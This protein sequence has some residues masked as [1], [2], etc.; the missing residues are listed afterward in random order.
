MTPAPMRHDGSAHSSWAE[1]A[2]H[3][4]AVALQQTRR[5][6]KTVRKSAQR[7]IKLARYAVGRLRNAEKSLYF[8]L[9]DSERGRRLLEAA[10]QVS[11]S[12]DVRRRRHAAARFVAAPQPPAIDPA[13]GYRLLTFDAAG[14]FAPA[15][16]AA[17]RLFA[18]KQMQIDEQVAGFEMWSPEQQEK[19]RSRKQSFLRYLLD[20]E[21]L[22]REPALLE[23]ALSDEML[24]S[25]AAYLRMV[26]YFSRLDLMYSL[27]RDSEDNIASQL[28]HLDHEGLTQ[29]KCFI[30]VFDVGEAEGPFTFIPADASARI[31]RDI[32]ALR[33]QRGAGYDVE[34]RR[35]LDEEI[36]AVGGLD[37]AVRLT[38][39]A[40]TGV[41]V[42]TSRCLHLGSRVASGTFRLCL[43]LQ[44]CT[45]R[46]VTNV[47]DV[48]RFSAD[49]IRRLALEHSLE[50]GRQLATDYTHRMMTG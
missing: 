15:L 43:Y 34:S 41:A 38:G 14:E 12:N 37:A 45:T 7:G 35:Y 36:R 50:P 25:A 3:L 21:D 8:R 32:R 40:G 4:P 48:S 47:F 9:R 19:Y 33:R 1:R 24:G 20:D 18:A 29:I 28:F 46:E 42:D 26:P 44:Y 30:N 5:Q 11:A 31:V 16:A 27:P 2:R 39:P 22:R 13:L 6:L 10:S 49:P 17:R 23:F